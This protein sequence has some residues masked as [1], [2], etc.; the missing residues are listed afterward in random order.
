M[1]PAAEGWTVVIPVK[2]TAGSKSRLSPAPTL[3]AAIALDTV[4]A[5]VASG[6]TSVV[7]VTGGD[8]AA[9]LGLGAEVVIDRGG[10]LNAAV[11]LGISRA[12]GP[13]AVMLGDLP[14]LLPAELDDAL[15]RARSH[16][17]AMVAD[18]DAEGTAF[19]AALRGE[20]HSPA[21]GT[22]SRAAHLAAGYV[23]LEVPVG[24]GLRRDVDTA[25]QLA[26]LGTRVGPRTA[27]A[28]GQ[29]TSGQAPV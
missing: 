29:A 22:G 11:R 4:E 24:S 21:F 19:I 10:G 5:A 17:L 23:E 1:R 3:A 28:L 2:G 25:G 18:A 15:G 8:P 16:E 20:L 7:V 13:V 9:F 27:A 6:A 14:A 26:Q 12:A